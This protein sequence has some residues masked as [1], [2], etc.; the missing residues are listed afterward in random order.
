MKRFRRFSAASR[1]TLFVDVNRVD[2]GLYKLNIYL[3]DATPVKSIA[4]IS[5]GIYDAMLG[6]RIA[7]SLSNTLGE[8]F[9]DV[10]EIEGLRIYSLALA[11]IL[12]T[13]V[14]TGTIQPLPLEEVANDADKFLD[15]LEI[16]SES[17]SDPNGMAVLI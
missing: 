13:A 16:F 9:E 1:D 2:T 12:D 7:L 8:I 5:E 11:R 4:V 17:L 10:P 3:D 15:Y 14:E 6:S